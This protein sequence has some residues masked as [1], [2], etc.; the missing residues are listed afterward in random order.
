MISRASPSELSIEALKE[1]NHGL[2]AERESLR[3]R[4]TRF[5]DRVIEYEEKFEAGNHDIARIKTDIKHANDEIKRLLAKFHTESSATENLERALKQ[6][7]SE[8]EVVEVAAVRLK[9]K[10][11]ARDGLLTALPESPMRPVRPAS[12]VSYYSTA[13]LR[14]RLRRSLKIDEDKPPDNDAQD[15]EKT[16]NE[17]TKV[18]RELGRDNKAAPVV[19]S[20]SLSATNSQKETHSQLDFSVITLP[21][22][23]ISL[24]DIWNIALQPSAPAQYTR[25]T[26]RC[27][28]YCSF[29]FTQANLLSRKQ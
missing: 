22:F 4:N 1:T 23:V 21:I 15:S 20:P 6:L 19:P 27:V 18:Y 28:S 10:M 26:W 17:M 8:K 13:S 7:R 14:K 3:H 24:L 2:G 29:S 11:A 25:I 12:A 5:H 16:Q 9:A